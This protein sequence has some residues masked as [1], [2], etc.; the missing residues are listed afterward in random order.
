MAIVV[1]G[2]SGHVGGLVAQ[3]LAELEV[4]MRLVVRD[5]ARAP[6]VSGAEIV[7]A[8]YGDPASLA[9][10]LRPGDRVF[11]VSLHESPERRVPLHR[12]FIEA[13]A[14]ADVAQV[15]YLSFANAGPDAI[16]LHARTHGATEAMLA[17]AGVPFTAVR[18]TMYADGMAGW[19]DDDGVAREP[20]GDARMSFSWR[21]ELARVVARTLTEPGHEGRVYDIVTP[22]AVS[23]GE[24]AAIASGVTGREF[25]Y[26]PTS[27]ADWVDR[28]TAA[29]QTGWHL[30]VGLSVYAALRAGEFD[31]VTGDY[32]AVTGQ[33]PATIEQ[34]AAKLF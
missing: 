14:R 6:Q 15:V 16:F 5:P 25:R 19:F 33:Q 1:T 24:L 31:V 27:D 4:P 32:E 18:N 23:L 22:E 7:A 13:A 9:E 30:D 3:E 29:G 17:D 8:D 34:L 28:W 20:A 10:A 11:M 26:E 21:P 2:A 12:S